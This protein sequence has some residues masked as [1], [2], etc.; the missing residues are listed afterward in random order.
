MR[1]IP[2]KCRQAQG[3]TGWS[4]RTTQSFEKTE[5]LQFRPEACRMA[6]Q[7]HQIRVQH[8]ILGQE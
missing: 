7:K 5:N 3:I 8:E 1:A 4:A 2:R 6:L